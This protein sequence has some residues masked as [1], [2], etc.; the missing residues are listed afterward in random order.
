MTPSSKDE[1]VEPS[2]KE[3]EVVEPSSKEETMMDSEKMFQTW[4]KEKLLRLRTVRDL[5]NLDW[6]FRCEM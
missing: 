3:E 1:V 2:S 4:P 5:T 6:S